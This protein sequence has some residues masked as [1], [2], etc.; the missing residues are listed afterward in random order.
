MARNEPLDFENEDDP[1]LPA[2]RPAKRSKVIGM[3]DLLLDYFQSG[4][5]DKLKVKAAKS[6]HGPKG[7]YDSGEEDDRATQQEITVCKIFEEVQQKGK[8]MDA[9]DDVPPWG[10]QF[11]RCQLILA[12]SSCFC[13]GEGFLE[14]MLLDG[15]LLNLVRICGFVEDSVASWTLTNLLHSPNEKL[16][17]SAAD[18]WDGILSLDEAG[19]PL[20]NLGYFPSYSVL[21]RAMLSYGYLF[22]TS[23]TKAS[24]SGSTAAGGP[25]DSL[26]HNII[27][28]LRVVSACCKIRKVHSIFSP[29]EAEELLAIAISLFLDRRL[30]GL[31]LV[32]GD[33]LNSL[34]L[35][36]NTS[37]WETSCVMVAESI[38]QRVTLDLNCLRVVDCITGTNKR[39]KILRSQVALQLLKISFGLKVANVEKILKLVTSINVKEKECDFFRLYVYLVLMD[40]LLF[41]S[42][43]FRDKTGMV[44]AW[45]NYLRNCSTQI[46]CTDWRFYAPKARNKASYLLQGSILKKS[47]G[48]GKSCVR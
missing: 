30:E 8:V 17:V 29:S 37:E 40:N 42:D 46:G 9:R 4:K 20:V 44:D 3:D 10:Q 1:L 35:Y 21:K 12:S 11:F 33:C 39:S 45:R 2:P 31:L 5:K 47:S 25:D 41:S 7:G 19:E 36:F 6:K 13:V 14:G 32:L 27:A 22:D 18:F 43:A 16:Q 34:I 23:G 26:P 28:W 24:I 48:D 15:W 38:A